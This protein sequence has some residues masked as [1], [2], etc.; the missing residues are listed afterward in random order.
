MCPSIF[1]FV[2]DSGTPKLVG[3]A[4]LKRLDFGVGQG[5]WKSTEW[6]GDNV[7]VA[8]SLVLRPK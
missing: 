3:T 5:D 2:T 8:F 4:K 1:K 7:N 6:V